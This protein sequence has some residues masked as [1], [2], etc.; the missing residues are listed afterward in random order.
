MRSALIC[1]HENT[2]THET[3]LRG[4]S[5][6]SLH[7]FIWLYFPGRTHLI[8][9]LQFINDLTDHR[10][11]LLH[12]DFWV[13]SLGF[14]AVANHSES[15]AVK[16][17]KGEE[18]ETVVRGEWVSFLWIPFQFFSAKAIEALLLAWWGRPYMNRL[19][20]STQQRERHKESLKN[21]QGPEM[22][23]ITQATLKSDR[24]PGWETDWGL[25]GAEWMCAAMGRR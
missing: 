9:V 24:T 7:C 23:R 1:W 25:C 5:R 22:G 16:T 4:T 2:E 3:A 19:H 10:V 21:P 13:F 6:S 8:D 11:G 17:K 12:F 15:V 14:N 20:L 18:W